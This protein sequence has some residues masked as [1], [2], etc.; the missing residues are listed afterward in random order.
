MLALITA[1]CGVSEFSTKKT[2]NQSTINPVSTNS[3]QSCSSFTLIKPNVDFLFL[4]DNSTSSV[5]INSQTKAAL[6]NLVDQ[7]SV[8]FDY[9]IAMAPLLGTGNANTKIVTSTTAG[10]GASAT[11]MRIDQASIS[12]TISNF[13]LVSGS[14]EAGIS[15]TNEILNLNKTNGVFRQNSYLIVVVMSNEDDNSWVPSG[16]AYYNPIFESQKYVDAQTNTLLCTRG[17]YTPPV[18]QLPCVGAPLNS[19]QMRFISLVAHNSDSPGQSC[20][21][22]ALYRTN[23]IYKKV[24]EKV[25]LEKYLGLSRHETQT[26]PYDSYNICDQANF[27]HIFDGVNQSIKQILIKHKYNYWPVATSGAAAIDP[28]EVR[29]FKDGVEFLKFNEPVAPGTNGFSFTNTIQTL[30]TRTLPTPGE[31]FTGYMVKLYGTAQVTYPECVRVTTKTPKE[32]YGYIALTTKPLEATIVVKING[33][34]V[35]KGGANGWELI[36]TGQVPTYFPSK[37]IKIQAPGV[38]CP[39]NSVN[40]CPGNPA[41]NKSGYFIKLNGNAVYSNGAQVSVI[42]DP[43]A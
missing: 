36:K 42:Y 19:T 35:N 12:N 3:T 28:A 20:G 38:F 5:F 31:P 21:G 26:T 32:Y 9:H 11:A 10:L 2:Q 23:S 41:I 24:S 18:G 16:V 1:S 7:V 30:N 37:N 25:Y 39:T 13:P 29:V 22:V 43:S 14:Y 27:S 34:I 15:R 40:Y 33:Q 4:W 6:T 8:D 17:N